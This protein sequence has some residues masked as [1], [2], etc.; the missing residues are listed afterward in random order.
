MEKSK[1]NIFLSKKKDLQVISFS[2]FAWISPRNADLS[3]PHTLSLF[4][5]VLLFDQYDA[6]LFIFHGYSFLQLHEIQYFLFS[7]S[8]ALPAPK[9]SSLGAGPDINSAAVA[10]AAAAAVN[11][12]DPA[13]C[14][15]RQPR[16]VF[17]EFEKVFAYKISYWASSMI[18]QEM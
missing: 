8:I 7:R 1:L 18:K 4:F 12:D 16:G 2:P 5:F 6:K 17:G 3:S 13:R 10:A 9:V 14:G 11:L 15:A